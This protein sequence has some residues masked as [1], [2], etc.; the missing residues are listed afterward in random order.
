M[1]NKLD[2][3][4]SELRSRVD[5]LCAEIQQKDGLIHDL[6]KE[7]SEKEWSLGE[8]RQWLS[9]ANNRSLTLLTC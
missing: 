5:S 8:H 9:D 6:E 3:Y 2:S 1:I 4:F 7:R